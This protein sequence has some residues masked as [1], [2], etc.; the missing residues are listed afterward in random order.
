MDL[1]AER[2]A[3]VLAPFVLQRAAAASANVDVGQGAGPRVEAGGKHQDV[4][5]VQLPVSGSH[6]AFGEALDRSFLH[7][8]KLHVV[9]VERL[10]VVRFQR[11]SFRAE[12]DR[13]WESASWPAPGP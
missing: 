13:W 10:E 7:V 5:F 9:A 12:A 6:S 8:D 1:Q 2:G 11:H 4:D 3:D